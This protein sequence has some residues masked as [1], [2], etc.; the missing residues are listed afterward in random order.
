MSNRSASRSSTIA[1]TATYQRTCGG[2]FLPGADGNSN[3]CAFLALNFSGNVMPSYPRGEGANDV[4]GGDAA[5]AAAAAAAAQHG[6]RLLHIRCPSTEPRLPGRDRNCQTKTRHEH[7]HF[8]RSAPRLD[9]PGEKGSVYGWPNAS[10]AGGIRLSERLP[11][12]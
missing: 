5:A 3:S 1:P 10:W 8:K 2:C 4:Y 11:T 7:E 12:S 6:A 9:S